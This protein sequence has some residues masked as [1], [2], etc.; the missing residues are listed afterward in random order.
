MQLFWI[1]VGAILVRVVWRF[2]IRRYSA[3]SG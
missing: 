3:V 2:A 1:V